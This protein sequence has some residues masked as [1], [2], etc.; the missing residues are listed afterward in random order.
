MTRD[1]IATQVA[2]AMAST[3]VD[4]DWIAER[5]YDIADALLKA[6]GPQV[7]HF[8][9]LD[10]S[11]P[12]NPKAQRPK[13]K[14]RSNPNALKQHLTHEWQDLDTLRKSAGLTYALILINKMTLLISCK[15]NK[16]LYF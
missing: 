2:G 12:E 16:M 8:P 10:V 5:A 7:E 4:A 14:R 1:E 11:V 15:S 6:R 3:A 9:G 13:K